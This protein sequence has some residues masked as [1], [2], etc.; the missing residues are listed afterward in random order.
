MPI[1][2]RTVSGWALAGLASSLLPGPSAFADAAKYA[3]IR[4]GDGQ[5]GS[6][7]QPWF[8]E[9]FLEF[10]DDIEEAAGNG[11][12]FALMWEL[13]G[14]PYCRET[15]LVNFAVPEIN[16]YVRANFEI[17]QLDLKGSREVVNFDGTPMKER[18]LARLNR[19]RHP[20]TI[21]FFPETVDELKGK[22]GK[23]MEIARMPGYLR[24]FHFYTYFQFV[25]EKAYT[26]TN[27]HK[28][29][30]ARVAN[31]K[32]EGKQLPSW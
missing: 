18:D 28:Y 15:H 13:E 14:C 8:L 4:K 29:L 21:Q 3:P 12:R 10:A 11:K 5:F 22:I 19:V 26:H 25:R 16:E 23:D 1:S 27:F 24:P 30:S 20:P 2:R 31:Y 32:A 17:V 7:T 9:S 6:Y